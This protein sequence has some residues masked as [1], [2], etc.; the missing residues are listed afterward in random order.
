VR[1]VFLTDATDP[2]SAPIQL[3][4]ASTCGV[5]LW[6]GLD[7]SERRGEEVGDLVQVARCGILDV[8]GDA[9]A[10]RFENGAF[11]LGTGLG[12]LAVRIPLPAGGAGGLSRRSFAVQQ[13]AFVTRCGQPGSQTSSARQHIGLRDLTGD[14]IPDLVDRRPANT[15]SAPRLRVFIGTGA[16]FATTPVDITGTS[17]A[18]GGI[19]DVTFSTVDESCDGKFSN[20]RGRLCGP[21]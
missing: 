21:A 14:G 12:F 9:I 7:E 1:G 15:L 19:P 5:G 18:V 6:S 17:D 2:F 11:W 8:N 4:A 3:A 13:S 20:G 16:G 10:D